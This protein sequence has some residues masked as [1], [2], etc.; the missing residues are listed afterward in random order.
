MQFGYVNGLSMQSATTS[1]ST[2][3]PASFERAANSSD[4]VLWNSVKYDRLCL[5]GQ[6]SNAGN[7]E[8]L[9]T[10]LSGTDRR[11]DQLECRRR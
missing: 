7:T 3:R 10:G 1:S 2:E 11:A 9:D 6:L 8:R 5:R 4:V